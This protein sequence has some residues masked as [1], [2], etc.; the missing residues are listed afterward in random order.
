MGQLLCS[1]Q[2]SVLTSTNSSALTEAFG[3][4]PEEGVNETERFDERMFA[5]LYSDM[6]NRE[7]C[8]VTKGTSVG[9][10]SPE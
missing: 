5:S 10:R 7:G 6:N 8:R 3:T 2:P 4:S 9:L 1:V